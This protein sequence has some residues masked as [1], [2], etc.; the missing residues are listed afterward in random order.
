M[1]G[2]PV[3]GAMKAAAAIMVVI[4]VLVIVARI[5][6]AQAQAAINCPPQD[7]PVWAQVLNHGHGEWICGSSLTVG[8]KARP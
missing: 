5:H 6:T 4:A 3:V 7:H 1:R 8:V 2:D